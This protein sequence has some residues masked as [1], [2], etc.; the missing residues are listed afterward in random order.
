MQPVVDD[1]GRRDLGHHLP[2]HDVLGERRPGRRLVPGLGLQPVADELLVEGGLRPPR[3][4]AV[5]GPVAGGVGGQHLVDEQQ[6]SGIHGVAEFE[7]GVGQEE[8]LGGGVPGAVV[9]ELQGQVPEGNGEIRTDRF[10]DRP[11]VDVLVVPGLGLGGGSEDGLG[12]AA[13]L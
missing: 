7:F 5:G 8:V 3:L 6:L 9:V 4:V 10:F 2:G 1:V 12:Q 13:R 11:E